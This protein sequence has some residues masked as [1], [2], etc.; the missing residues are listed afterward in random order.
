MV[1]NKVTFGLEKVHIAFKDI[2][3]WKVPVAIPGAVGFRPS[4]EGDEA[5]FYADNSKYYTVTVNNGYTAELEMALIPDEILVEMLGWEI[6]ENGMVI[7]IADGVQKE[8]ALM[9]QVQG[10]AKNRKFVYYNCKASRPSKE[11]ST[12][13]ESIE[14]ST[15]VLSLVITPIEV[16][17]KNVV[18]GTMELSET[19]SAAYNAFFSQVVVPG[20]IIGAVVKTELASVIALAGKLDQLDYTADSWTTFQGVLTSSTAVNA[21]ASATQYEVNQAT[22]ALQNAILDLVAVA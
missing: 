17:G 4:A 12:K 9:G 3:G 7:E 20:A 18:K 15:D 2:V 14:P 16:N 1:K 13:A 5:V 19:N 11:N 22:T 8:F 21:N 10:D 6:D